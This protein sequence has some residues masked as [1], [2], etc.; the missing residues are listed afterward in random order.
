M[1]RPWRPLAVPTRYFQFEGNFRYESG[2][3]AALRFLA[4]GLPDAILGANDESAIGVLMALRQAGVA[5]PESLSVAGDRAYGGHPNSWTSRR[6]TSPS[7]ESGGEAARC[8][9]LA[10]GEWDPAQRAVLL[11]RLVIR[12]TTARR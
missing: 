10:R 9:T 3:A 6:S 12:G 4:G 2:L 11:H 7:T 8:V 5:V 1:W